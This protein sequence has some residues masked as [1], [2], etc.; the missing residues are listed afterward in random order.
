MLLR[1]E[2]T[3]T[4]IPMVEVALVEVVAGSAVVARAAMVVHDHKAVASKLVYSA[5]CVERRAIL[6]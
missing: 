1:R 6:L 2:A 4:T 3:T 5:S